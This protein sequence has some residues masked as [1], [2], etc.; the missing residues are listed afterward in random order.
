MKKIL[1]FFALLSSCIVPFPAEA[2]TTEEIK[3]IQDKREE[4][5]KLEL[6]RNKVAIKNMFPEDDQ[7]TLDLKTLIVIYGKTQY[8]KG[9]AA[10][11]MHEIDTKLRKISGRAESEEWMWDMTMGTDF[12]ELS[13][14]LK[15]VF[16]K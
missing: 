8:E 10:R 12:D 16:A 11:N 4:L 13:E 15:F 3:Q 5:F 2:K 9:W 6:E 14:V 1:F 7:R